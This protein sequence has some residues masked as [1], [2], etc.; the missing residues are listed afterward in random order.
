M[1]ISTQQMVDTLL[2]GMQSQQQ[3]VSTATEQ[4]SSGLRFTTAGQDPVAY[5]KSLSIRDMQSGIKG[6]RSRC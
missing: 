2:S 4:L 3:T 6:S 1:I 5:E